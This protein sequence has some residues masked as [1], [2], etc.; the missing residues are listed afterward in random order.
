MSYFIM[1][2]QFPQPVGDFIDAAGIR[3]TTR[4]PRLDWVIK[5]G[6]WGM[7]AYL[8]YKAISTFVPEEYRI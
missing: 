5:W 6:F 7:F 8:A 1:P 3:V 4:N 2:R